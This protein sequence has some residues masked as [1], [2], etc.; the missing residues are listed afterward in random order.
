[1]EI[2]NHRL[3]GA[4]YR[5]ARV[6]GPEIK[7]ELIILHDT[8]GRLDK[9]SSVKWFQSAECKTSAHV[10]I[11]R[12]G[13]I[14]QM[15]PFNRKAAHAGVSHFAGRQ[16]CNTFSIGIEIVNP[17]KL[18]SKGRAWFHKSSEPG[19]NPLELEHKITNEH[20]DGYWMPYTDEQIAAVKRLCRALMQEY[21][22]VNHITTHWKVSPR[23]KIDTNPLF[24]LD[25]VIAYAEGWD[26]DEPEDK[27]TPPPDVLGQAPPPTVTQSTEVQA[28]VAVQASGAMVMA[29]P[30]QSAIGKATTSGEFVFS[31]FFWALM[32]DPQFLTSVVIVMGG[33]YAFL[34]RVRRWSEG[35]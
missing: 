10:V 30:V 25:E 4:P 28:A 35:S 20:G 21:P 7:P 13:S 31:K 8:A 29:P 2:K 3:V 19:F 9:G 6:I 26:D 34:K 16:Y 33:A 14:V 12:D 32:A 22:D 15:V 18:D 27:P 11:E 17:G 1:M 23:R 24:P 5:A